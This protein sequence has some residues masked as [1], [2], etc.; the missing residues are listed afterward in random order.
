[1]KDVRLDGGEGIA[2]VRSLANRCLAN[3]FSPGYP[4]SCN[5]IDSHSECRVASLRLGSATE[6]LLNHCSGASTLGAQELAHV[7]AASHRSRA[8]HCFFLAL[9]DRLC[10]DF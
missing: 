4:C 10:D 2:A 5:D 6:R 7:A 9:D 8:A 3:L 1:M